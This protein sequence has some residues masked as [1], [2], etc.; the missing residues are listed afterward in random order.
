M[1][2][3]MIYNMPKQSVAAG[4]RVSAMSLTSLLAV[5]P[6]PSWS[7][8]FFFTEELNTRI[9]VKGQEDIFSI[10]FF[11]FLQLS[12]RKYSA[13]DTE[14]SRP[15]RS[16]QHYATANSE[17]SKTRF[18]PSQFHSLLPP[19]EQFYENK[20]N[21]KPIN[22]HS[23]TNSKKNIAWECFGFLIYSW[24]CVKD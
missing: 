3:E 22:I 12:S 17:Q 4:L 2:Y 18:Y 21:K 16:D 14:R 6:N 20:N 24:F 9:E 5:Y 23:N 1:I 13:N 11:F 15:A 7:W 8:S 19:E 10:L